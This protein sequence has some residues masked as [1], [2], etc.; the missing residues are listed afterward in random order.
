MNGMR[1]QPQGAAKLERGNPLLVGAQAVLVGGLP[2][3]LASGQLLTLGGSGAA[4]RAVPAGRADSFRRNCYKATELLPAIGT[5]PYVEYWIG[6]PNA[7]KLAGNSNEPGFLTGSSN[8]STGIA[9][10]VWS[11]GPAGQ[12]D[13]WGAVRSWTAINA[14]QEVLAPDQLVCLVVVRRPD[15]MEFWR[16]GNLVN[17]VL[18]SPTNHG[19]SKFLVGAFIESSYW[20]ANSDMIMAGRL[21]AEWSPEQVRSFSINPWQLIAAT[22][23]DDYVA[24]ATA[25]NYTLATQSAALAITAGQ[26]GMRVS[27]Q[28]RTEPASLVIAP[29]QVGLRASRKLTVA[30]SAL[31]L[32]T[33]DVAL[34]ASRRLGVLPAA[35]AI[36]G[37]QVVGRVSRRL[38]VAPAAMVMTGGQVSM[39]YAQKP[40]PGSYTLPVSAAA[41][42]LTGGNVGMRVARRLRVTP[43]ILALAAGAVRTLVGRRL[44]VS[45]AGLQLAGGPVT[46]SFSA[47]GESF[48]ISKIHPSRLVIFEGSGSRITPFEGSGSRITPFEGSGSRI[49][50]FE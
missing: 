3:N 23:D 16:D 17:S 12:S 32:A 25:S 36:T 39:L 15:R 38:P 49:T 34:L 29:G 31:T 13:S 22:E 37:G 7:S 28:L 26:V 18:Q 35:M 30:L 14:A 5:A 24:A 20:Y 48:D 44:M 33:S 47:R 1:Y 42:T 27:R 21:L 45:S 41:M 4:T 6:Y 9:Q 19:A 50:R 8:N 40:E 10:A 43:A 46:L 11:K 2:Y